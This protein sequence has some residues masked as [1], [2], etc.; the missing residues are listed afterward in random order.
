MLLSL[1]VL[2][3]NGKIRARHNNRRLMEAASRD[4]CVYKY[5]AHHVS[6]RVLKYKVLASLCSHNIKGT[7]VHQR[8]LVRKQKKHDC[9]CF[10]L[11][12]TITVSYEGGERGS[13][14]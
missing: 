1:H 9:Q 8:T 7:P 5:M 2:I 6:D 14:N 3:L 11:S 10:C 4:E 13:F 12:F